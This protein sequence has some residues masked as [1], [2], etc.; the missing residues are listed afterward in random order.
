MDN[1]S[2]DQLLPLAGKSAENFLNLIQIQLVPI[3]GYIR[4]KCAST[5]IN[6][7]A[8]IVRKNNQHRP[9]EAMVVEAALVIFSD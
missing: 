8:S 9:M 7:N 1:T 5:H 6:M 2:V 3:L 4:Y